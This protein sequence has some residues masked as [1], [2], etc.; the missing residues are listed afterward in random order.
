MIRAGFT[1]W[2]STPHVS[3]LKNQEIRT[4]RPGTRKAVWLI[5]GSLLAFAILLLLKKRDRPECPHDWSEYFRADEVVRSKGGPV[6][7]VDPS[8]IARK[9]RNAKASSFLSKGPSYQVPDSDAS[10]F[11]ISKGV[12]DS[13]E[14]HD[15]QDLIRRANWL[16]RLVK[17]KDKLEYAAM[18]A[19]LAREDLDKVLDAAF[20]EQP[21]APIGAGGLPIAEIIA[22]GP[23]AP[24]GIKTGFN[25]LLLGPNGDA[26]MLAMGPNH[27]TFNCSSVALTQTNTNAKQLTVNI[28][29]AMNPS[30]VLGVT[31]FEFD[32][33]A[34]EQ[35]IGVKC[36]PDAWCVVGQ[37]GR[38]PMRPLTFATA[39][40][41]FGGAGDQQ[42]L[43]EYKPNLF[44]R[45]KLSVSHTIGSAFPAPDLQ[46]FSIKKKGGW[47][48]V[49][50]VALS[51]SLPTYEKMLGFTATPAAASDF[52][53][54]NVVEFCAGPRSGCEGVPATTKPCQVE[55]AAVGGDSVWAKVTSPLSLSAG[56]NVTYRC[57]HYRPAETMGVSSS[58][59]NL[60]RDLVR[61]R[62]QPTDEFLWVRCP[63]GCCEAHGEM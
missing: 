35:L 52:R 25:C 2:Q 28:E 56:T 48:T 58:A 3:P 55:P 39:P 49:A 11:L 7:H 10:T 29:R 8:G 60:P 59:F 51:S 15:C 43:A 37:S 27:T 38:R 34:A 30:M 9:V 22:E 4:M 50:Y 57:V 21:T 5:T 19:V 6:Q 33:A 47:T 62:W 36:R 54:M 18:T 61:F 63:A 1:R 41:S 26:W 12:T 45:K 13:P 16:V 46:K 31:R 32:S 53:R 40:M 23:Y 44:G 14:V 17:G 42:F 24:L 20:G